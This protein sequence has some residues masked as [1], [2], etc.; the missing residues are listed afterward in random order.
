MLQSIKKYPRLSVKAQEW[1]F[2]ACKS[3]R[4]MRTATT[5]PD[6]FFKELMEA[7]LMYGIP[8]NAQITRDGYQALSHFRELEDKRDK[9]ARKR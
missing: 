4:K 1:L 7:G 3:T 9:K 8:S 6:H 2:L 5:V